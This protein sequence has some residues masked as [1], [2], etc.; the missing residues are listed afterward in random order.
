MHSNDDV[1][2]IRQAISE[3]LVDR[4]HS[5]EFDD[6]ESLFD[7]GK[8]DSL[9]AVKLLM[10]LESEFD[11]DLGDPDFEIARIDTF[12]A[13]AELVGESAPA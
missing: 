12:A 2:I 1:R 4:G 3:I 6:T 8:L 7:S 13:I 9:A 11:I 5:A 10:T